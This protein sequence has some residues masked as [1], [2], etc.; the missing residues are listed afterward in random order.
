MSSISARCRPSWSDIGYVDGAHPETSRA[1]D[2]MSKAVQIWKRT[3][4][5]LLV[6]L[7]HPLLGSNGGRCRMIALENVVKCPSDQ[8]EKH[9]SAGFFLQSSVEGVQME[10]G[11]DHHRTTTDRWFKNEVSWH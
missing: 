10:G 2:G 1:M 8:C 3:G 11:R 9:S 5:T 7:R 6:I 4:K